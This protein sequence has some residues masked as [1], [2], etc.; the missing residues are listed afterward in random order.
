MKTSI[1]SFVLFVFSLSFSLQGE[2]R[3][4]T[5]SII[6]FLQE[7]V[8]KKVKQY[9]FIDEQGS[10][11]LLY[12]DE[13]VFKNIPTEWEDEVRNLFLVKVKPST[14]EEQ[15]AP[16]K[17]SYKSIEQTLMLDIVKA[18]WSDGNWVKNGI[19][20]EFV[21]GH[22]FLTEDGKRMFFIS[23]MNG[24][25]GGTDLF[26]AEKINGVWSE[27]IG[28]RNFTNSK[29]NEYFPS[30]TNNTLRYISKGKVTFIEL[31]E[32]MHYVS[33][34]EI[35][36]SVSKK[37]TQSAP[38]TASTNVYQP[39]IKSNTL[40]G[41]VYKIQLGLFRAPNWNVL[42]SEFSKYGN[43][44]NT[45]NDGIINVKLGDFNDLDYIDSIL[46]EIRKVSGFS[47]AFVVS[48]KNGRIISIDE[49]RKLHQQSKIS[50]K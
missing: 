34:S 23:D 16:E 39:P 17:S 2:E 47:S 10:H 27:P 3:E 1:I 24:T 37:K 7:N 31:S 38:T 36:K 50:L 20:H 22:P 35:D 26:M 45:I 11:Q 18:R 44:E 49:A 8:N 6:N 25:V 40:E 42:N 32:F 29:E 12:A 19:E 46:N 21:V 48:Y 14:Q 13:M 5:T 41:V 9:N 43:L 33:K 4:A 30:I 15:K 28:L